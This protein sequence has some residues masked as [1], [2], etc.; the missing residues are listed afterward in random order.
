MSCLRRGRARPKMHLIAPA[1]NIFSKYRF[2]KILQILFLRENDAE[3]LR[4]LM[5][6][7]LI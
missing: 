1:K 2:F 7:Q 5:N 3:Q 6:A 4:Q